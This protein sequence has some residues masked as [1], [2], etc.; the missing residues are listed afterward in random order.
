LF[1]FFPFD[2]PPSEG[3]VVI[4]L[5]LALSVL[6]MTYVMCDMIGAA[7]DRANAPHLTPLSLIGPGGVYRTPP[8]PPHE[9]L[10]IGHVPR[11]DEVW[12]IAYL[13]G[14]TKAVAEVLVSHAIAGG[15]L[16]PDPSGEKF[17]RTTAPM[18]DDP[19]LA[20]FVGEPGGSAR[21]AEE[22][23]AEAVLYA[24]ALAAQL[25]ADLVVAR[26]YRSSGLVTLLTLIMLAGGA[27]AVA[28]G[29]IRIIVRLDVS[30][31]QAPVPVVIVI[32]ML[33]VA[34]IAI[35]M[36]ATKH[37]VS[38]HA[39]RYLDWLKDATSSLC[40]DVSSGRRSTGHEV[41]IAAAIAGAAILPMYAAMNALF[42]APTPASS[43]SC[44]S[45][46]CGGGGG[47]GGGCG[48][49]GGCS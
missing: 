21:P 40:A 18:P 44:S 23:R 19:I 25:E 10:A 28:I 7:A 1:H 36:A 32:A 2:M 49:G 27:V 33:V 15:Y 9:R 47:C 38:R 4:Y 35:W 43:G 13:R 39:K 46:S 42:V 5:A 30:H 31:G 8:T 17:N 20:G 34:G 37:R 14:K 16:A 48:G 11:P 41:A 26:A 45:S 22:I 12:A 29:I 24:S 6:G 3:W